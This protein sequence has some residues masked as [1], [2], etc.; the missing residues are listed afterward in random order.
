VEGAKRA[1]MRVIGI[2]EREILQKAELVVSGFPEIEP[3]VL[4]SCIELK[5]TSAVR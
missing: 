1:G 4:L 2:G 5:D 3:V